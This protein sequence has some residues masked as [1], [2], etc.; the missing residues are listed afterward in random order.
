MNINIFSALRK[1]ITLI[2]NSDYRKK[3]TELYRIKHL[4]RFQQTVVQIL[5]KPIRIVDSAS[6]LFQ[7]KE[8]FLKKIYYF[9]SDKKS[10]VI[11]DGGANIGL[12]T[13]Y[14][15]QL[16]PL[17]KI[18]S[19]EPSQEIF[20]VL[21]FNIESFKFNDVKLINSG[22]WNR[23]TKV[24]FAPDGA[25]GGRIENTKNSNCQIDV[26]SLKPF[27]ENEI[28]FLKLDIEGAELEVLLDCAHLLPNVKKLFVEYHSF[29]NQEQKL[30]EVLEI[31]RNAGMRYYIQSVGVNSPH[32]YA[33]IESS[34]GMDLQLNIYGYR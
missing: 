8:I 16:F 7:Y 6:F 34:L 33:K 32:P 15:K 30:S 17:A 3:H 21:K 31:I 11:I 25:D 18:V 13:I 1:T 29:T 2:F 5:T 26:I 12:S 14:W 24:N 27:L 9:S 4:K 19:F 20:E 23:N 22:L 10:P 28:D